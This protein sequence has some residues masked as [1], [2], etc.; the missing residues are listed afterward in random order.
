MRIATL[1][2]LV[3]GLAPEERAALGR[4]VGI[5]ESMLG[6]RAAAWPRGARNRG[7]AGRG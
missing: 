3:R 7:T 6:Q 5:V 1:E 4:A 2:R